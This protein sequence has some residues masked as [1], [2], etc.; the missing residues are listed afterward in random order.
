MAELDVNKRLA[1]YTQEEPQGIALR[2]DLMSNDIAVMAKLTGLPL[3]GLLETI[4]VAYQAMDVHIMVVEG[5]LGDEPI[6][7]VPGHPG[8]D[9]KQ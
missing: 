9:T 2:G 5:S 7:V 1:L 6:Q 8:T 3:E 4:T